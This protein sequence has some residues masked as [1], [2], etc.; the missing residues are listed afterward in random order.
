VIKAEWQAIWSTLGIDN[1][2]VSNCHLHLCEEAEHLVSAGLDVFDREQLVTSSTL[3]CWQE[4]K[5][6]AAND[7]IELS[8]VSAFR[9]I[10]YQRQLISN[11]LA[12]G[13]LIHDIVQV[14]AIPGFS[15][16]H[17]G[18]AIDIT[19]ADCKPLSEAFDETKA[20]QWLTDH[21]VDFDFVMSYPKNNPHNIIYEP[22]HWMCHQAD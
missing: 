10:E 8:I 13:Q 18:K 19:T 5:S 17:T 11:K 20:F 1:K 6:A 12:K 14:N 21:A 4:M 3:S 7:N 16:H 22:W 15:E 9:S 2:L